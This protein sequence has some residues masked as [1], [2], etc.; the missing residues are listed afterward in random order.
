MIKQKKMQKMLTD[1]GKQLP[2]KTSSRFAT[3]GGTSGAGTPKEL[4]ALTSG[5]GGISTSA[6]SSHQRTVERVE[7]V[8]PLKI[9]LSTRKKRRNEDSEEESKYIGKGKLILR[10]IS[11]NSDQ[12][13]ESL[14][15]EHERQLDE[16]E[17]QK[18]ERRKERAAAKKAKEATALK[19]K[20]KRRKEGEGGNTSAAGDDGELQIQVLS[21]KK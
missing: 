9:R 14:L 20:V 3:T 17:R 2:K 13:F 18:E 7:K 11:V 4:A 5:P 21:W 6:S 10:L 12:E 1:Q 19:Q 16:E 15:K 8:A